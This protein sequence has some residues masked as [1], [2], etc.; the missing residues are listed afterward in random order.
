M[1]SKP[2]AK[3]I[4]CW[5][6]IVVYNPDHPTLD[7]LIQSLLSQARHVALFDNGGLNP[8]I[9]QSWQNNQHRISIFGN[10]DNLGIGVALNVMAK[11]AISNNADYF[12]TFD[13]DSNPSIS[14]LADLT[15]PGVLQETD[16]SVA[17]IAPIFRDSRSG[18]ILPIFKIGRFWVHKINLK[19]GNPVQKVDI[20]ITSGMLIPINALKI[21]GPFNEPYF[22]DHIDTEW[23]L[24]ARSAG[25]KILACPNAIMDHELSDE[26]PKHVLGRLIL[27][28]SPIR[29]YYIFRNSTALASSLK[30]PFSMR[31]YLL[32]TLVYRLPLNT[33]IDTYRLKS[34]RS[35]IL[36]IT[37]GLI[38][39]LGRIN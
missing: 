24:R 6:G 36:G 22:I 27:K 8:K 13:Q 12:W 33:C 18:Q 32:L 37:H 35:M 28:Y 4:N 10:G 23:C 17:A 25:Q 16:D 9:L 31:I 26:A 19:P 30:T 7:R 15:T 39:R 3:P 1:K 20:V 11:A 5:S 2:L 29:R 38:N 34:L 14:L 21:V